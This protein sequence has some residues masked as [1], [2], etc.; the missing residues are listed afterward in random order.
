M[1]ENSVVTRSC[2]RYVFSFGIP[3]EFSQYFVSFLYGS[4]SEFYLAEVGSCENFEK[5]ITNSCN[6]SNHMVS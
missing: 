3:C 1:G 2:T 6:I 5:K 4:F